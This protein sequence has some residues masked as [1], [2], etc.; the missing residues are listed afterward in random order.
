MGRN[1]T[2]W[3][4]L[5]ML[6][7][8]TRTAPDTGLAAQPAPG[9]ANDKDTHMTASIAYKDKTIYTLPESR[10]PDISS[11][12]FMSVHKSGSTLMNNMMRTACGMLDYE[13]VDIQSHFFNTG[14]SDA[15]I[16]AET[17]KIFKPRGYVYSGFRY[18]PHQYEIPCLNDCP[19]IV[20]VRDP[21]DAV[22]SQYFS[23]S[24]SHPMPG[25]DADDKLLRHME[26]KRKE[27][28]GSDINEFALREVGGFVKKIETYSEVMKTHPKAR[29]FQYEEIIYMKKKW[30][31]SMLN[32]LGWKM[33]PGQPM[34]LANRFNIVPKQE[35]ASKHIRQVHP[36]NYL[37][38]LSPETINEINRKYSATLLR[39]NYI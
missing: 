25:K 1:R 3:P 18:F 4:A 35:D 5:R 20:L 23:L 24:Q 13:F 9:P 33:Q 39:Y 17:S 12:F 6:E 37:S 30:V 14:V 11:V 32:F 27:T 8:K 10:S 28:L 36:Q 7:R 19:L 16:P 26:A 38:K 31:M 29:L 22:V 34:T 2:L 21:R 15:D